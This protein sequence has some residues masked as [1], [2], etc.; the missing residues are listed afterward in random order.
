M[1]NTSLCVVFVVDRAYYSKFVDTCSQLRTVGNYKGDICLIIGDDLNNTEFLQSSFI[2]Q[3]NIIVKYYPNLQFSQEFI[4]NQKTLDREYKWFQKLFQYHKL[5]LFKT[6][7]KKWDYI[8]YLDCGI[9]IYS[10][11]SP[12][13]SL[14]KKNTLLAHSDDY[15]KYERKLWYQFD[16]NK[17]EYEKLMNSYKMDIDY[18]QT[19]IMLFDTSIIED[20]TFD[21][22]FKLTNEYPISITNDQGIIALYYTCIKPVFKPI[23]LHN[24]NTFFY[25]YFLREYGNPYIMVKDTVFGH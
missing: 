16:K 18:P 9:T 8:F 22:L 17:K 5:N 6:Y 14:A 11:V 7:F 15:P 23:P 3:Y 25:D 13:I 1:E 2:K 21:N 4:E 12:M 24:E 20:D 10:D 19:T